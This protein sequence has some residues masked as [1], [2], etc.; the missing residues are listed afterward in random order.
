MNALANPE[1]GKYVNE[2]FV[3][4][5]QKVGT[6][7][8]V[9]KQEAGRQRRHLL[10][11]LRM[12][13]CC[14][15]SPGRSMPPRFLREAKWVV[16][17]TEKAIKEAKG[18]GAAFKAIL[19]KAHAEKLRTEHG[20]VVEPVTYDPPDDPG[21]ERR[22]DLSR[23]DGPAAGPVLPPPPIDGPD[24]KF[25]AKSR[26]GPSWHRPHRPRTDSAGARPR[27]SA[28]GTGQPGSRPCSC[29]PPI[30]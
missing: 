6:F 4:S 25:R 11:R 18:D 7:R 19:R 8:I 29:S 22:A 26:R 2:N 17:T 28:L 15:P 1:V 30:R 24:V 16:E 3:S 14:T 13:A 20:L 27:R 5:F 10:L 12:A 21:P 23:S 9:G